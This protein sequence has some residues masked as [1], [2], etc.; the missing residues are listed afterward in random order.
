M[1]WLMLLAVVLDSGVRFPVETTVVYVDMLELN[2]VTPEHGSAG[3]F[4]QVVAWTWDPSHKMYHTA[5][6]RQ[7]RDGDHARP[8]KVGDQWHYRWVTEGKV[9]KVIAKHY[10]ETSTLGDPEQ[11]DRFKYGPI[12]KDL[13]LG[14]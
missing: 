7:I 1:A 5:G 13:R 6:W 9:V 2:M 12:C 14:Y 11:K 8:I 10:R 4:L 3:P